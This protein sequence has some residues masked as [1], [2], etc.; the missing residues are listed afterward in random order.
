[1]GNDSCLHLLLFCQHLCRTGARTVVDRRRP[2]RYR[3]STG[4]A[5][6]GRS[7]TPLRPAFA[8][9]A[10]GQPCHPLPF[11]RPDAGAA[12]LPWRRRMDLAPR[13]FRRAPLRPLERPMAQ[14]KPASASAASVSRSLARTFTLEKRRPHGEPG[15]FGCK[16]IGA[17][18]FK[19]AR[20]GSTTRCALE[21]LWRRRSG[22]RARTG[23]CAGFLPDR[24]RQSQCRSVDLRGRWNLSPGLGT[25]TG[26]PG[27]MERL[28]GAHWQLVT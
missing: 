2:D 9:A 13:Q 10:I 6:T 21:A 5:P 3:T 25:K 27:K 24:H 18:S 7:G 22:G 17:R 8:L 1:M 4:P 23:R 20:S 12:S 26:R 16:R 28:H 14:P 11:R 19:P 15:R